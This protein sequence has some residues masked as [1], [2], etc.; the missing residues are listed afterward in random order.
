MSD[1]HEMVIHNIRKVVGRKAICFHKNKVL[2]R[3]L[4]LKGAIDSILELWCAEATR[5]Q[6][7]NV[8]LAFGGSLIRL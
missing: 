4:L 8:S 1:L 3:L 7:D 2:F 5:V 6:S